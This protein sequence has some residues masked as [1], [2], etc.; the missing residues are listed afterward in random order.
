MGVFISWAK[1]P[2]NRSCRSTAWWSS[3]TVF[4]ICSAMRLK[5]WDT[6]PISSSLR[7]GVRLENSPEA[8][9]REA[10]D[11]PT[12]GAVSIRDTV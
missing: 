5:S 6:A 1:L 4:S 8:M 2:A 10:R 7:T 11:S 9:A 3:H 12:S